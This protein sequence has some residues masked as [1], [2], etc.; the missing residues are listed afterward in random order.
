MKPD[1]KIIIFCSKKVRAD[2][3]STELH[4]DLRIETQCIHGN[5]DQ[6]LKRNLK[7]MCEKLL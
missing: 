7:E 2:D 6:V 4:I 5:R 1:D 3:L